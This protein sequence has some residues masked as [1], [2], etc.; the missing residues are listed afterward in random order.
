MQK[1][2]FVYDNQEAEGKMRLDIFLS[3]N[4]P[5]ITRSQIKKMILDGLVKVN[6]KEASVHRF[7]KNGDEIIIIEKSE[8]TKSKSN[9][10]NQKKSKKTARKNT[11]TLIP[12]IIAEEKDYL[13]LNKPSGLLV[14]PTDKNETNTLV[15]WLLEKYP[16]LRKIGEDPSRPAIVHRLDK[17]VSGLI[18]IPRNQEAFDYFK[19]L[20]KTKTIIKKYWTLVEGE[21]IAGEGEINFPISRS[22]TKPGLFAAISKME[23]NPQAKPALTIFHVL[24]RL[25]NY[26]LLEVQILTGRT[27]QI[28]V[29]MLAYGHPVV[30]DR[31]YGPSKAKNGLPE[32]IFLHARQ[33]T[34][35]DPSGEEKTYASELPEKLGAFLKTLKEK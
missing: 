34:F 29:H 27:H 11:V 16:E 2:K 19:R 20:F 35:I 5:E 13:I 14:H 8:E 3:E 25:K 1:N 31:L 21:V 7:L 15:D 9:A 12:E 4:L 26:T 24:K 18:L 23:M 10:E 22:K 32:R 6:N 17:D 28:R 30:S 33:L